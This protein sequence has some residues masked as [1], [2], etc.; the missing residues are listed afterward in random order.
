ML[1]FL[2]SSCNYDYE[3]PD[4]SNG[5]IEYKIVPNLSKET[6][7]KFKSIAKQYD[8]TVGTYENHDILAWDVVWKINVTEKDKDNNVLYHGFPREKCSV[9]TKYI[10]TEII[11]LH[12][13]HHEKDI[14]KEYQDSDSESYYEVCVFKEP[15]EVYFMPAVNEIII[16]GSADQFVHEKIEGPVIYNYGITW[17]KLDLDFVNLADERG[18]EFCG[19]SHSITEKDAHGN[20]LGTKEFGRTSSS[21]MQVSK[22]GADYVDFTLN[23]LGW[24]KG[25]TYGTIYNVLH[26]VFKDIKLS[27]ICGNEKYSVTTKDNYEIIYDEPMFYYYGITLGSDVVSYMLDLVDERGYE[28]SGR[29]LVITEKDAKGNVLRVRDLG[30]YSNEMVSAEK[31]AEYIDVTVNVEGWKKGNTYG[32][33]Y[34]VFQ[35]VFKD[36]KLSDICGDKKYELSKSD[37]TDTIFD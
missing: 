17:S 5:F 36:I 22:K 33:I 27:D 34:K 8:S 20:I 29:S 1:G 13:Y 28:F 21:S 18:Y 6:K 24:E 15:H 37:L 4:T 10:D 26:I 11:C 35:M 19:V 9:N 31:N 3:Y 23:V 16:D 14:V 25:K 7:E 30:K 12:G 32:T 2:L